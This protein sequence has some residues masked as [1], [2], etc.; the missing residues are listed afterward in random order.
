M[1]GSLERPPIVLRSKRTRGIGLVAVSVIFVAI[2]LF[3]FATAK[4]SLNAFLNLGLFGLTGLVGIWML[5]APYR[6]V[7]GPDGLTQTM[8]WRTMKF[9]WTDIY[10]FRPIGIGLTNKMIGF[11]YLRD[12]PKRRALRRLN[13]AFAGVQGALQPGWEIPPQD[14]ANILNEARE[15]WLEV[16]EGAVQPGVY[17]PPPQNSLLAALTGART[18]R[19][20]FWLATAIVFAVAIGM[21]LVGPAR[22]GL[23]GVTTLLFVRIYASRLHD[24]GRSGWWQLLLYGVQFPAVILIA[25]AGALPPGGLIGV[26]LLIQL[27]FTAVIGAIPG[28]PGTNRFGP[29][30]NQHSAIAIAETFR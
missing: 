19:K 23:A 2:A 13:A 9:A 15:R 22:S 20:G 29:P 28:D 3:Q 30:P 17:A 1:Q 6:L 24:F 8:L 5:V 25:G 10:N 14:L 11:D 12:P 16:P 4:P 18:N 21:S 27:V 7:I 26:G